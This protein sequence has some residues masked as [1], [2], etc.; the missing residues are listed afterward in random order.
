MNSILVTGFE[1]FDDYSI[2]PSAEVARALN[3]REIG[4]FTI[5][6]EVLPLD[7]SKALGIMDELLTRHKPAFILLCGQANRPTISIER[8]AVNAINTSRPDNYSNLPESDIID[9]EEPAAYFS[10]IDP[11]SLV[12]ALLEQEIPAFVSYHAGTFGCNW[13]LFNVLSQIDKGC[14]V[15]HATFIHLPP[16]PSQAIEKNTASTPTMNLDTQIRA[17]EIIIRQLV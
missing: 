17:L 10:S 12:A 6:G 16:L 3:G 5:I 2:N 8:I 13:L 7:Y 11:H 15:A 14:V 1:P 4:D 9:A